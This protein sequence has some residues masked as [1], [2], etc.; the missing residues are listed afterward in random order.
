MKTELQQAPK[1]PRGVTDYGEFTKALAAK[2]FEFQQ[3]DAPVIHRFSPGLYVRELHMPGGCLAV[4]HYH[5]YEHFNIFL[6]GHIFIFKDD[7][8]VQELKAPMMFN[9]PPGKKSGYVVEDSIWLNVFAT[10]ETDV[11]A[12]EEK[13]LKKDED[14]E[15]YKERM[16]KAEKARIISDREDYYKLIEQLGYTEAEVRKEV[17][18][19][20]IQIPLPYGTYKFKLDNSLIEGKGVFATAPIDKG[21]IIGPA[22]INNQ[23]TPLGRFVNHS[24]WPN[25]EMIFSGND[26]DLVAVKSISGCKGG[27]PGEEITIDYRKILTDIQGVRSCQQS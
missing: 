20:D 1:T 8:T 9:A 13:N 14:F 25:A 2:L 6:E 26:L 16:T 10:D 12:W 11:A 22:R 3:A 4:G 19:P 18:D 15:A 17:E 7:G 27:L 5:K 23:K 21:E 24:L